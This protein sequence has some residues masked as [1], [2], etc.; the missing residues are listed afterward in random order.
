MISHQH[1]RYADNQ[2]AR[3]IKALRSL[4]SGM[5]VGKTRGKLTYH[6]A[7]GRLQ[8]ADRI[9]RRPLL[10]YKHEFDKHR[11]AAT[12][13]HVKLMRGAKIDPKHVKDAA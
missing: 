12:S 7:I 9:E 5:T 1:V 3:A 2:R 13:Y 10:Q 11:L 6:Q 8:K 4:C